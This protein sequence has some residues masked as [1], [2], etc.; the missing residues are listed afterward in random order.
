[1]LAHDFNGFGGIVRRGDDL[2]AVFACQERL[3]AG[4][5][6]EVIVDDGDANHDLISRLTT[7]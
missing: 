7:V 2:H 4:E 3:D 6:D 5:H 1:M